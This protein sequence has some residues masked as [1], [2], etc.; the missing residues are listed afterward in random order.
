M[1]SK[2]PIGAQLGAKNLSKT[3]FIKSKELGTY[4]CEGKAGWLFKYF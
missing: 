3:R 2:T 4:D 1:M